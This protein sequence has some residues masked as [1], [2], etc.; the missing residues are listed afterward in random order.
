M[1]YICIIID[2]FSQKHA[3]NANFEAYTVFYEIS[4]RYQKSHMEHL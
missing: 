4:V 1:L 3:Y 2:I